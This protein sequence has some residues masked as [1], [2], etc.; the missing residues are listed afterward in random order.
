MMSDNNP[1]FLDD[2]WF[3]IHVMDESSHLGLDS[4]YASKLRTLML[5][6]IEMAGTP[7][8]CRSAIVD[9]IIRADEKVTAF[10]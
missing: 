6:Q 8:G 5:R 7:K 3:A 2:L 1:A 9:P 4:E 10:S